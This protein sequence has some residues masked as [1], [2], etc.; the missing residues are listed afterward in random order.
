MIKLK[1]LLFFMVFFL[2]VLKVVFYNIVCE[3]RLL[4]IG[5][6]LEIVLSWLF[7]DLLLIFFEKV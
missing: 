7:I 5:V 6:V 2:I 4:N 3:E 1:V